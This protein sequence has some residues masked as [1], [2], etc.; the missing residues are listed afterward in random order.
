MRKIKCPHCESDNN[1]KR[2]FMKSKR[3][4]TARYECKDCNKTFTKRTGTINYRH[5][6][7][8]LRDK[9]K[10]L[11]C[12]GMSLRAIAR[13][14]KINYKTVVRYFLENAEASKSKVT[15]ALDK[16][17]IY[18][19]YIQFDELETF[20]H[21]KKRPLGVQV[22]IRWK[23]GEII[24]TK[25]CKIPVKALSVS[26]TYIQQ[27]NQNIDRSHALKAVFKETK[28]AFNK[29]HAT[30]VCDKARQ[31][32]KIANEV[33]PEHN[34]NI[35]GSD[36]RNKRIDLVFLKMRQDISRLRRKTLATTKRRAN[37]QKHL[38]LYTDYHNEKRIA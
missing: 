8:E 18:T 14:E 26:K 27:W 12:E 5:R 1:R 35:V 2:G 20:E 31:P 3:G 22:S 21:T 32:L 10:T 16:G 23:T 6:K 11:Y 36:Q 25:V 28:K 33:C 37:L 30:V 19:S 9:L 4:K 7:Q 17:S 15:K 13:A 38:D 29:T 24:S 34:V